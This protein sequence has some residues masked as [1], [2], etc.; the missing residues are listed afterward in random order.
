M[1][2]A[3][4]DIGSNSVLL[5]AAELDENRKKIKK[6]LLNLSHIT[7]L[8]KDLD[9][10]KT[11]HPESIEAT[12][13]ALLDYKNELKKIGIDAGSVLVTATEASRVATNAKDF[14]NHIKSKLGFEITTIT[15]KG[16]AYYTALGVSSD[17]TALNSSETVIMDIGGASTELIRVNL[18]PF[19]IIESISLPVGSVRAFDWINE[20]QFES[21]MNEIFA[22]EFSA[23]KT[24]TL[25]C[26]AGGM[27]SLA[28]MYV[29]QI[30]FD[31]SKIDGLKITI[32]EF[33]KF[34]KSLENIS[35]DELQLKFPFLGKRAI[36][37][38]AASKVAS[39][40]ATALEVESIQV[41][42]RGLRYG[43]LLS[44]EI[45]EQFVGK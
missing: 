30:K 43:T 14:F 2:R 26:V 23:Y 41:S 36:V 1:I 32:D 15:S 12:F 9:K 8:G 7:S 39:R 40:F 19:N 3:S 6:E 4:I 45:S 44:G 27:T 5:L 25:L 22:T 29:G 13:N 42:T 34:I 20:K 11:F 35:K 33:D 10:N 24:T 28:A 21:K 18:N 37:I 38:S 17:L 31:S 16:E